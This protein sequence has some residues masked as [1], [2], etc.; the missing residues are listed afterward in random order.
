MFVFPKYFQTQRISAVQLS[1]G[2][3]SQKVFLTFWYLMLESPKLFSFHSG[4]YL[5]HAF[6]YLLMLPQETYEN[7]NLTKRGKSKI[8]QTKFARLKT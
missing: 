1:W 8:S 5:K 2:K 6:A 7:H 4:I 3:T